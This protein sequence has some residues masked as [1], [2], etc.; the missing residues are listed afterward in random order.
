L[1]IDRG[2][3]LEPPEKTAKGGKNQLN[4]N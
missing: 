3:E 1:L 2:H 4:F